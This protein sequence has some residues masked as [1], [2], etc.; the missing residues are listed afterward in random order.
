MA[1]AAFKNVVLLNRY[2]DEVRS[3]VDAQRRSLAQMSG[4][5]ARVASV[6]LSRSLATLA[7]LEEALRLR[8]SAVGVSVRRTP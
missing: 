6:A 3:N 1:T 8:R 5:D 4:S 2:V 7:T